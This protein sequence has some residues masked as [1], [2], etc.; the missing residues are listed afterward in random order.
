MPRPQRK[1]GHRT[2]NAVAFTLRH[3]PWR[4]RDNHPTTTRRGGLW[5]VRPVGEVDGRS[6][7][8]ERLLRLF[9][10]WPFRSGTR[11]SLVR[12]LA[13]RV[14]DGHAEEQPGHQRDAADHHRGQ[15][16]GLHRSACRAHACLHRGLSGLRTGHRCF[17]GRLG[18]LDALDPLEQLFVVYRHV[19]VSVRREVSLADGHRRLLPARFALHRPTRVLCAYDSR[20][21]R[22]SDAPMDSDRSVKRLPGSRSGAGVTASFAVRSSRRSTRSLPAS[23]TMH[24]DN[25][26]AAC[27]E[28]DEAHGCRGREVRHDGS[29]VQCL[30]WCDGCDYC[31]VH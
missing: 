23:L 15:I 29:L 31:G 6:R 9:G 18:D 10:A 26:V 19:R 30:E 5:K 11:C 28:D 2:L 12:A 3:A 20:N 27:T 16:S 22:K 1:T 14:R 25:T 8:G 7:E 4:I 24:R 17:L 13:T 21:T